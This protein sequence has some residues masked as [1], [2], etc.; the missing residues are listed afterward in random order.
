MTVSD[1]IAELQRHPPQKPVRVLMPAVWMEDETGDFTLYVSEERAQE[2][3][4]VRN[5][6]PWIV[7]VGK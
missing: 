2:V 1:L 3:D 6:G 7:V 4:D 5:A